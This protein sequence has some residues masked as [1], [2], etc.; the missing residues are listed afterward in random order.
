MN[1]LTNQ[2]E[3][4]LKPLI[5]LFVLIFIIWGIFL[6]IMLCTPQEWVIKGQFGDMF[7]SINA[8]FSGLAFGGVIFTILLQRNEL[9]LQRQELIETRK[10][11]A[12]TAL[13]QENSEKALNK[14]VQLQNMTTKLNSLN[15]LINYNQEKAERERNFNPQLYHTLL[16]DNERY[17][18]EIESLLQKINLLSKE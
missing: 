3:D 1:T 18:V 17:I 10:K 9:A 2:K 14:Q 11:L 5:I 16:N 13:A 8:L 4:S 15:I 7:G 12:R 6:I